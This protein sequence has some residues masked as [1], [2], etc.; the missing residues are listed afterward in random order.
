MA[1]AKSQKHIRVYPY[2][3]NGSYV[4]ATP[5]STAVAAAAVCRKHINVMI[6][7]RKEFIIIL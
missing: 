7:R 3:C 2:L 6:R 5:P 4:L 1:N